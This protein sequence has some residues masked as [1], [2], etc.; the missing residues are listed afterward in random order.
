MGLGAGGAA[1]GGQLQIDL[2]VVGLAPGWD[3]TTWRPVTDN[4]ARIMSWNKAMYPKPGDP[5]PFRGSP[6]GVTASD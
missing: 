5:E 6:A 1:F 4:L 3:P 2:S